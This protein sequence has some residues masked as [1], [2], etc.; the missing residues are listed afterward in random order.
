MEARLHEW[1]DLHGITI[2]DTGSLLECESFVKPTDPSHLTCELLVRSLENPTDFA[3]FFEFVAPFPAKQREESIG[4]TVLVDALFNI[5]QTL[6]KEVARVSLEFWQV[7]ANPN[8]HFTE[9]PARLEEN[10]ATA[11]ERFT[12]RKGTD[13]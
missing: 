11:D 5:A 4:V 8:P 2:G 10:G 7:I 12:R 6:E 9:F 13:R 1:Q 3:E